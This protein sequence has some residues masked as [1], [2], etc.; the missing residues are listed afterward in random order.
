MKP[1][2]A[3]TNSYTLQEQPLPAKTSPDSTTKQLTYQ[4]SGVELQSKEQFSAGGI[5]TK[6]LLYNP[7]NQCVYAMNLDGMNVCEFEAGSRRLRRKLLFK[8]TP[9]EG[10]NYTTKKT[11]ASYQEKPVEACLSHAGSRLWIS[12][13]NAGGIVCWPLADSVLKGQVVSGRQAFVQNF[14]RVNQLDS[15]TLIELPFFSTGKTPKVLLKHPEKDLLWVSNWHQN[16]VSTID[17]AGNNPLYWQ[18]KKNLGGIP[19][20]RGLFFASKSRRLLVAAMG[21]SQLF[22]YNADSL[23]QETTVQVGLNPR[24]LAGNDSIL[25][26][27]LNSAAQIAVIDTQSLKILSKTPTLAQPR[28]I[29]L[30]PDGQLLFV[31]CYTEDR[32]QVF[33]TR[34]MELLGVWPTNH[35]PVGLCIVEQNGLLE[36]WVSNYSAGTINVFAFK[37]LSKSNSQNTAAR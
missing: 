29:A 3:P 9:G 37:T 24:H 14:A 25:Y 27:S 33:R 21:S 23:T 18:I 11:F 2:I 6:S 36:A 31:V 22:V 12:L 10:F 4:L 30:S 5:G 1:V 32:L 8:P 26:V 16:N 13:H 35:H 15:T 19:V 17:I 20:P 34:D 7:A 28:T